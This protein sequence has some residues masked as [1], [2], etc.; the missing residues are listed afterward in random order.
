M[1]DIAFLLSGLALFGLAAASVL[2]AERL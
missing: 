1:I 2:A